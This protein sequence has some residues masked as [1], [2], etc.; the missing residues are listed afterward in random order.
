[1]YLIVGTQITSGGLNAPR[2]IL[3]RELFLLH[4]K[5]QLSDRTMADVT[6]LLLLSHSLNRTGCDEL[7]LDSHFY[8]IKQKQV[9]ACPVIVSSVCSNVR[10]KEVQP[11]DGLDKE[12]CVRCN[13]QLQDAAGNSREQQARIPVAA[14]LR[15]FI[16]QAEFQSFLENNA[17]SDGSTISCLNLYVSFIVLIIHMAT[18]FF[19]GR[20]Y[21]EHCESTA[22]DGKRYILLELSS[23]RSMA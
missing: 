19:N 4:L 6:R 8:R 20:I 15:L 3:E 5:H 9:S 23:D 13:E 7:V 18:A 11:Q 14:W 2:Q 12:H 1:L 16:K 21:R 22:N 17:S 10:C